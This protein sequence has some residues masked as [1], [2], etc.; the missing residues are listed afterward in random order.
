MNRRNIF[1]V[2]ATVVGLSVLPLA[3]E[4][5]HSGTA[6]G[7][8]QR[9]AAHAGRALGLT[10]A[11]KTAARQLFSDSRTQAK[12]LMDQLKQ[13]RTD[14]QTAIKANDTA[15]IATLAA[16][17]GQLSGQLAELHGKAMASF[18]AQLTPEQKAKADERRTQFEGKRRNHFGANRRGHHGAE[19]PQA[20]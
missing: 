17:Q 7:T 10:D 11:Q 8:H 14:M 5:T 18:Y 13:N 3:A 12:P 1:A 15:Q 4:K 16:R 9:F 20:Q 2:T 6:G 19:T